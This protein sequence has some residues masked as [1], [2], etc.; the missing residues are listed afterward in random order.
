VGGLLG[1]KHV[2]RTIALVAGKSANRLPHE[3]SLQ[4][5]LTLN[6]IQTDIP[7]YHCGRMRA[8]KAA[9]KALHRRHHGEIFRLSL[10]LVAF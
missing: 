4:P 9:L 7:Q 1:R 2:T 8:T 5:V 10:A 3:P 6:H